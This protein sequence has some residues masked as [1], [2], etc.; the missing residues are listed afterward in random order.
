MN[1]LDE[2]TLIV[3]MTRRDMDCRDLRRNFKPEWLKEKDLLPVC[4]A[5]YAFLDKYQVVP[6]LDSVAEF[7][8]DEDKELFEIRHKALITELKMMPDDASKQLVAVDKAKEKAAALSLETMI[9]SADFQQALAEGEGK[10]L[11]ATV[12]R[13]MTEHTRVAGTGPVDIKTGLEE[14]IKETPWTGKAQRV[15]SGILP[16]DKWSGGLRPGQLGIVIAPT[17][18]GKST[19]LLNIGYNVAMS[20]GRGVLFLTNELTKKDQLERFL[21][22]MQGGGEDGKELIPLHVI[23]DDPVAAYNGLEHKWRH[24]L[25]QR[26]WVD[27]IDLNTT[28]DELETMMVHLKAQHNFQP[29][30]IVIDYMEKMQPIRNVKLD[31]EWIYLQEIAKELIRLGQRRNCSVWTAVQTNR[32]GLNKKNGIGMDSVQGSVRHLQAADVVVSCQKVYMDMLDS[33]VEA[34]HFKEHKMRSTAMEGREMYVKTNLQVMYIS[35]DEVV[36]PDDAEIVAADEA[37]EAKEDR[38]EEAAKKRGERK[39]LSDRQ[40]KEGT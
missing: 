23:Q 30:M 4:K 27:A 32:S 36:P 26:L 39:V 14:L 37:R 7:M 31:K 17:G 1:S 21:A 18:G 28:A 15:A 22:R 40:A 9:H 8:S 19:T 34:M 20:E 2:K 11:M 38:Q 5:I 24:Q 3:A 12:S 16:I 35:N 29:E 33:K 6:S 10:P 25:E 13:W